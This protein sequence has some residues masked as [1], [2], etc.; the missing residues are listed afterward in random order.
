MK[1]IFIAGASDIGEEIINSLS[2]NKIIY[3]YRN[4]KLKKNHNI[5]VALKNIPNMIKSILF[6]KF[7]KKLK[8]LTIKNIYKTVI[9]I[10]IKKII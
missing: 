2:K 7:K 5:N 10:N 3:T 8:C 9:N 4:L 6:K 1:Y